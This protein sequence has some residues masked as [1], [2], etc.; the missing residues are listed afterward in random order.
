M[1][2]V[3]KLVEKW[4]HLLVGAG[5]GSGE[6]GAYDDPYYFCYDTYQE[7]PEFSQCLR[8]LSERR[9]SFSIRKWARP[10]LAGPGDGDAPIRFFFFNIKIDQV[11]HFQ[12]VDRSGSSFSV[13]RWLFSRANV[14]APARGL[15]RFHRRVR[16]AALA[17]EGEEEGEGEGASEPCSRFLEIKMQRA[18][19][20]L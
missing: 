20:E 3:K 12:Y 10:A 15:Y 16:A 5:G 11:P 7:D 18:K 19:V 1:R 6:P 9:N 17:G 14:R 8:D 2:G 4:R 13:D